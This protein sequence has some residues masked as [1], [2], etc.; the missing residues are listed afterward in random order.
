MA[1][2]GATVSVGHDAA[3][4]GN[5]DV[6]LISSAIPQSNVEVVEARRRGIPVLKRAEFL[7]QLMGDKLAI[8]V[9]GTAG[10]TTT[11]S[12][13]IW[14]LSEAGLDPTFI[15]GGVIDGLRTNAR[16][17][18]GPHFVIEADEYDNM[19]LGLKPTVAAV[20]HLE[21]DH[22]DCFPTLADIRTAF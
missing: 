3:Q 15:V 5:V 13:L 12:M 21:H 16:A 6:V 9:A 18:S 7:G 20:T 4:V 19:F 8:A 11:T 22:P 17:G 1:D 2:S 14:I 10:K